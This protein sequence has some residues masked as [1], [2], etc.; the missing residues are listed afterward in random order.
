MIAASQK[1]E[2]DAVSAGVC[3]LCAILAEA[4]RLKILVVSFDLHRAIEYL[5]RQTLSRKRFDFGN[6]YLAAAYILNSLERS[7]ETLQRALHWIHAAL[8]RAG[9]R[10]RACNSCWR[11]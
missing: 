3:S 4:R 7:A 10:S 2:I 6:G 5:R 9:P 8:P 11:R 1:G